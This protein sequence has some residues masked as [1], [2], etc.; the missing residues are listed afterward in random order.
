MT[1]TVEE[2]L[3]EWD[4][5]PL[6]PDDDFT[7]DTY[8]TIFTW[9]PYELDADLL[10]RFELFS[11]TMDELDIAFMLKTTPPRPRVIQ[12]LKRQYMF[13][14]ER[15]VGAVFRF[16]DILKEHANDAPWLVNLARRQWD[17]TDLISVKE[18]FLA[19]SFLETVWHLIRFCPQGQVSEYLDAIKRFNNVPFAFMEHLRVER[20]MTPAQMTHYIES[21]VKNAEMH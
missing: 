10:Q 19:H 2:L 12:I 20:S 9:V 5:F 13:L 7:L 6:G 11:T 1:V 8:R 4:G 17:P 21:N 16:E 14:T 15:K 18:I 3:Q